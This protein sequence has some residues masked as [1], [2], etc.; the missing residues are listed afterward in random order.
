MDTTA[1]RKAGLALGTGGI[2]DKQSR[3]ADS[4]LLVAPNF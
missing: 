3:V 1:N 2:Y 4:F